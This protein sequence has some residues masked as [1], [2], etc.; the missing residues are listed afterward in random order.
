MPFTPAFPAPSQ[1]PTQIRRYCLSNLT[2]FKG[3]R[4]REVTEKE[5][6]L[7]K[8][9]LEFLAIKEI[10]HRVTVF[11]MHQHSRAM[12]VDARSGKQ[13]GNRDRDPEKC[14]HLSPNPASRDL[15]YSTNTRHW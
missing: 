2:Q 11:K 4:N 6:Q 9:H 12:E 5:L 8:G 10:P 3:C 1:V 14:Y 13:L 15:F 7:V